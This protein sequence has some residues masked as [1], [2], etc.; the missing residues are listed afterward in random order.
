MESSPPVS[1]KV[2]KFVACSTSN[3]S[4]E[5]SSKVGS[6]HLESSMLDEAWRDPMGYISETD[7]FLYIPRIHPMQAIHH[8][9]TLGAD[10]HLPRVSIVIT[11]W[12]FKQFNQHVTGRYMLSSFTMCSARC[13][14]DTLWKNPEVSIGM[15]L[16]MYPAWDLSH[17]LRLLSQCAQWV[18]YNVISMYSQC[19]PFL[20]QT[21]KEIIDYL[22]EYIVNTLLGTLW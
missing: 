4:R 2:L 12:F 5:R 15:Q 3:M 13:P 11:L 21:L 18:L 20:P 19:S 6:R 10:T 22:D 8:R 14:G 1:T 9:L 7:L 17:S 16:T